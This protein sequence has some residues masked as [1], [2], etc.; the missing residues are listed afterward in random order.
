MFVE[1]STS[2]FVD[3]RK[4]GL[5]DMEEVFVEALEERSAII[6]LEGIGIDA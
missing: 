4:L 6:V 2:P 3:V 1:D 5:L